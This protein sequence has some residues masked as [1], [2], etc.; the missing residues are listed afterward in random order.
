MESKWKNEFSDINSLCLRKIYDEKIVKINDKS[1]AEF[2]FKLLHNLLPNN[3]YLSKWNKNIDKYCAYCREIENT[4]HMIFDCILVENIWK[5]VSDIL[6][7]NIDW[8]HL[9]LGFIYNGNQSSVVL[10]NE[11][12]FIACKIFKSKM[13]CKKKMLQMKA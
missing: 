11:V 2:N 9:V 10:N 1:I 5:K 12:S 4:K 7:V 8:K 3:L 6:K 13:K